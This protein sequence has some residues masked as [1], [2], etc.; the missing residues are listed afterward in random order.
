[1]DKMVRTAC[2]RQIKQS[3]FGG[4]LIIIIYP[5]RIVLNELKMPSVWVIVLTVGPVFWG[6]TCK[7]I[8]SCLDMIHYSV[9][10]KT[11]IVK[12][13][14]LD[15]YFSFAEKYLY[16]E[17]CY[18]D[19]NAVKQ[20]KL[21]NL[22][23]L[24]FIHDIELLGESKEVYFENH[25]YEITFLRFSRLVVKVEDLTPDI[26]SKPV[27]VRMYEGAINYYTRKVRN[28]YVWK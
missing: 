11:I 7:G 6:L 9:C 22:I 26:S 24:R 19:P 17:I 13:V 16:G 10:T 4:I 18:I 1:M 5:L 3:L 27:Y 14:C 21:K 15:V 25:K 8:L 23:T 28:P 12:H 2:M 20:S